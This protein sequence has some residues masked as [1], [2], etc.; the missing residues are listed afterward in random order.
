MYHSAHHIDH[1][2]IAQRGN[3][4]CISCW[5]LIKVAL[6][7]LYISFE[8]LESRGSIIESLSIT[9]RI[10]HDQS[11]TPLDCCLF[12]QV[13]LV[14]K[15]ITIF[16]QIYMFPFANDFLA[17]C[18]RKQV[19][20]RRVIET[21]E[22]KSKK[23]KYCLFYTIY[24]KIDLV[25]IAQR[26]YWRKSKLSSIIFSIL[27]MEKWRWKFLE[28]NSMTRT[29]CCSHMVWATYDSMECQRK[30]H[31]STQKQRLGKRPRFSILSSLALDT[32]T[33]NWHGFSQ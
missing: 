27:A 20:S 31:G 2:M 13:F 3:H 9:A 22:W 14:S 28:A 10:P 1:Y 26:L 4:L 16:F 7:S 25:N 15:K 32:F 12:H 24:W 29:K 30:E 11:I 6:G 23:H 5:L 19:R 33:Y 8:Y 21:R 18:L 17:S